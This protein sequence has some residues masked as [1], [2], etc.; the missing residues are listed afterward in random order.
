MSD[1][2][3]LPNIAGRPYI[4][5]GR[6]ICGELEDALRREWLVTN[7]LGGYAS[8]TLALVNTRRYHGLLVA[9][10]IPP[11]ERVVMVADAAEEAS[12]AGQRFALSTHEFVGGTID[13]HGHQLVQDFALEGTTPRWR[14]AL[15]DALLDRRIW[16]AHG[17]NTTYLR[18]TL[19]RASA[20]LTLHITP[21]VTYRDFHTLRS[22][23]GWQP[24]FTPGQRDVRIQAGD[25][26]EPY[27]ILADDGEFTPSGVWWWNFYH[28]AEA[29]RG[30]DD[31]S[32]LYAVGDFTA[33]LALGA[34]YTLAFTTDSALALL[35]SSGERA[36]L[37]ERERQRHLLRQAEAENAEPFEQQ[38]VLAADQF[39]VARQMLVPAAVLPGP[40][41]PVPLGRS[42]I[43][44]Y[45][46]FCDWGRD[47]MIALPGLAL[48]TGRAA[49]AVEIL[50]TYA[51]YLSHGM[52]P[53]NFPDRAGIPPGYN[54]V[55]A[56]LWFA[57]AIR[58]YT[59]ATGDTSLM[60]EL[61]PALREIIQQHFVGTR[62]GI[63]VDPT[64]GL[65]RAGQPGVALTWMDAKVGDWVVTPRIGKP[66]EIQALWYNLLRIVA[67]ELRARGDGSAQMDDARA[68]GVR[69]AFTKRFVRADESAGVRRTPLLAD[70]VDGPAGD[71]WSLRPNQ[72][73]AVSLPFPLVEGEVAAGV[74]AVV[75]AQLLTSLGLRSLGQHEPDYHG[76]YRGD[77]RSRDAAYH[78]GTVWAWL[79]GPYIEAL[80]HVTGD[81]EAARRLLE[82]F[83][84]HLLDAGLGSISEIC[85]G[86]PPFEPQGCI[87]QAWSVAEVL[88]VARILSKRS[89]EHTDASLA[90]DAT[91]RYTQP[92]THG[93]T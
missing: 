46:W 91:L 81:Y 21:L 8:G 40:P 51:H 11:V 83:E 37:A 31:R 9:A 59:R 80:L 90:L 22:G 30:L 28:R 2:T 7:G 4:A 73:F 56:T 92:S 38:L 86:D 67:E 89:V 69:E 84:Q 85:D 39:L 35:N 49:E 70:V 24:S 52:L 58:A 32:D 29:A 36:L 15:G 10:I 33:T 65:L 63:H 23:E 26:T 16:M 77:Q 27:R 17:A 45:H 3:P 5:I 41:L 68:E 88:R 87:A 55:D 64:D 72:I 75:G 71:D 48:A 74:V 13:P 79:I 44:G 18:Y 25:G 20:P 93:G 50:R 1:E 12:Y 66:V 43:A 42:V 19:V 14:Y 34:S 78:Q 76:V 82:P 47:T 61:L 53:N 60:D 54:T 6:S 57:L 62:F